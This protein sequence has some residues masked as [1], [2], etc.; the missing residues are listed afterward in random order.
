MADVEARLGPPTFDQTDLDGMR[1]LT[2][3]YAR[4]ET[5]PGAAPG[6]VHTES[7]Y[8]V[9]AFKNGVLDARAQGTGQDGMTTNK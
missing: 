1:T 4:A 9:F 2:Y 8:V 5:I 3:T 6:D 7:S